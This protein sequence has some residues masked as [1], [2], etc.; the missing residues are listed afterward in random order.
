MTYRHYCLTLVNSPSDIFRQIHS[1]GPIRCLRR[2]TGLEIQPESIAY[3]PRALSPRSQH[4]PDRSSL[5][6]I[7]IATPAAACLDPPQETIRIP[8]YHASGPQVTIVTFTGRLGPSSPRI[9]FHSTSRTITYLSTSNS[10]LKPFLCHCI[11]SNKQAFC[12]PQ[13]F[14][15]KCQ[16][17]GSV[18][19][20]NRALHECAIHLQAAY[21]PLYPSL[22]I[23]IRLTVMFSRR[24]P[25]ESNRLLVQL[26]RRCEC[27][28]DCHGDGD[29]MLRIRRN[30][31]HPGPSSTITIPDSRH[32]I[33]P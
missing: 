25:S 12:S 11:Q 19:I 16:D 10:C 28:I 24:L 27:Q 6:G 29:E 2:S 30:L 5:R 33:D 20:C 4:R 23:T 8:I 3:S 21:L 7:S 22:S 1:F 31:L 18:A 14:F 17:P 32:C 26:P 9:W 13:S 15:L